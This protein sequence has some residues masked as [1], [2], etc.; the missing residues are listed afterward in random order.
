MSIHPSVARLAVAVCVC[1]AVVPMAPAGQKP[2]VAVRFEVAGSLSAF[3]PAEA[4]DTVAKELQPVLVAGIARAFPF[5]QVGGTP[6]DE[7]ILVA[8][9]PRDLEATFGLTS[10]VVLRVGL[11]G[12]SGDLVPWITVR[13]SLTA[14]LVPEG[15]KGGETLAFELKKLLRSEAY[16]DLA[17]KVVD[18]IA[19]AKSATFLDKT[20]ADEPG[21]L[22]DHRRCDLVLD[23]GSKLVVKAKVSVADGQANA[24]YA[25]DTKIDYLAR[26]AALASFNGKLFC[27][28]TT[29]HDDPSRLRTVDAN[30]VKVEGIYVEKYK[31]KTDCPHPPDEGVGP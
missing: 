12:G 31:R 10:A 26:D 3:V 22:L 2:N 8:L 27:V 6:A 15:P 18:R 11:A 5:L 21:W 7:T 24:E 25:A 13:S 1:V 17:S 4:R 16:A 29:G 30:K 20:Q 28:A 9:T 19:L 14:P 23:P